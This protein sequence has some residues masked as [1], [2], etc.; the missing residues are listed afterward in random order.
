VRAHFALRQISIKLAANGFDVLRF[1]YEGTGNSKNTLETIAP[2]QWAEN[3]GTASQELVNISGSD[4]VS[5]IAVRF[6]ANL[7]TT[8]A[9]ER[10]ID[11]F[12]M[13]DPVLVGDHWVENLY[14][15]RRNV[16]EVF[17][18][19]LLVKDREFMGHVTVPGFIDEIHARTLN[20]IRADRLFSVITEDYRHIDTLR[21][22][23]S[24][25][26]QVPFE[27]RWQDRKS[28][29]LGHTTL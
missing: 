12:I 17:A 22:V 15:H 3:I 24:Q 21:Q 9:A 16:C 8:L 23:S 6:A 26:E 2:A 20:R 4:R 28:Q 27:C 11:R 7:A 29:V 5:I 18:E 14:E 19:S 13:W 10:A 25:I 1:D